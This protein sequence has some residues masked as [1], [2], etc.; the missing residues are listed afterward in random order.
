MNFRSLAS[1]LLAF[2][3]LV[4]IA[5][6]ATQPNIPSFALKESRS[7]VERSYNC[8]DDDGE[9]GHGHNGNQHSKVGSTNN[10]NL[11]QI[12]QVLDAYVSGGSGNLEEQTGY[13]FS[14]AY[15]FFN[16]STP[17]AFTFYLV[18][19]YYTIGAD[20][21]IASLVGYAPWVNKIFGTV[22]SFE[23]WLRIVDADNCLAYLRIDR[24]MTD[25][26]TGSQVREYNDVKMQFGNNRRDGRDGGNRPYRYG[27]NRQPDV[28]I[29]RI[30]E[31][32]N[33]HT[34]VQELFPW[35][36]DSSEEFCDKY[37]AR[38]GYFGLGDW[39]TAQECLDYMNTVPFSSSA[40]PKVFTPTPGDTRS[41]RNFF[42]A[43]RI[44]D[45]VKFG[46]G[47]QELAGGCYIIGPADGQPG[48]VCSN[49]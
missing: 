38:C 16:A 43:R 10:C 4:C 18:D 19:G 20:A 2:A 37:M 5:H 35:A 36:L 47:P 49:A 30:D 40:Y 25:Y 46:S 39:N 7:V 42:L 33:S 11:A 3:L 1:I 8:D 45:E 26:A 32:A 41:C 22:Y 17:T 14:G 28:L 34:M 48:R 24:N 15:P 31:M 29:N 21:F 23:P 44:A 13:D 9:H 27:S 6:A 12:H